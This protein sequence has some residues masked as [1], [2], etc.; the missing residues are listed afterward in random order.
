MNAFVVQERLRWTP[1]DPTVPISATSFEH[2]SDEPFADP[3]DYKVLLNDWPYGFEPGVVHLLVW[4]KTPI[5]VDEERGDVTT[6]SRELIER[7]VETL[8]VSRVAE[9]CGL[10]RGEAW[11]RVMWFKNWE[12]L[13]SVRG[14]PHVHVLVKDVPEGLIGEWLGR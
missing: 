6:E 2:F 4:T 13:Q 8:F 10:E 12:S 5:A 3:R 7:F 11:K 1:I 9:R 14:V